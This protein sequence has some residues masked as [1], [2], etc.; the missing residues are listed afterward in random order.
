MSSLLLKVLTMKNHSLWLLICFSLLYL[1]SCEKEPQVVSVSGISLATRSI[2]LVEGE[3][4]D[5]VA[6]II[7]SDANNQRVTW[8]SSNT[9]I[10]SVNNGKVTAIKIGH[11]II[12]ATTEDGG[13]TASC[14]VSVYTPT[15]I[16]KDIVCYVNC[17]EQDFVVDIRSNIPFTCSID[18]NDKSWLSLV[19]TKALDTK[20]VSFHTSSNTSYV[21][22][23]AVIRVVSGSL[24]RNVV[25][26]QAGQP[27][28]F[29][30]Q[31]LADYMVYNYDK[32]HDK[33]ITSDEVDLI[34]SFSINSKTI[35]SIDGLQYLS[36]LKDLTLN[37]SVG[38]GILELDMS[39]FKSLE[40]LLCDNTNISHLLVSGA[41]K[42]RTLSCSDNNLTE[43]DLRDCSDLVTLR[44]SR[45]KLKSLD[46]TSNLQIQELMC[47]YCEIESL[48]LPKSSSCLQWFWCSNNNITSLDLSDFHDLVYI[49]CS[50]NE[51][52]DLGELIMPYLEQ[53]S[54]FNNRISSLNLSS[55]SDLQYLGCWNNPISSLDCSNLVQLQELY[56]DNCRIEELNVSSCY[57]IRKLSCSK[58]TDEAIELKT[59]YIPKSQQCSL[60]IPKSTN[61]IEID[62]WEEEDD[63]IITLFDPYFKDY[64]VTANI[65]AGE[66]RSSKIDRN[67]DG[68]ISV[69]EA[70]LVRSIYIKSSTYL[71]SLSG[72]EYL[73]NLEH[74]SIGNDDWF[75][76]RDKRGM[77]SEADLSDNTKLRTVWILGQNL[78]S[79]SLPK[80]SSLLEDVFIW[81]C[82]LKTI[83]LS[84]FMDLKRLE[85]NDTDIVSLD[86]SHNSKLSYIQVNDNKISEL[87]LGSHPSLEWLTIANNPIKAIDVS[88]FP[89]LYCLQCSNTSIVSLDVH[90]N[91][92]LTMLSCESDSLE[93]L[94]L[95]KNYYL[96]M[97]SFMCGSQTNIIIR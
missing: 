22:R 46:L 34:T 6:T 3:I 14:E 7:P 9:A 17:D 4:F 20:T 64:L 13:F 97:T 43:L 36:N 50:N 21:T 57:S 45:N 65:D 49:D 73:N 40:S 32:N 41:S 90:K 86:L 89:D 47:D 31:A 61:V 12:T 1:I 24:E 54:C 16:P 77:L 95:F 76:N 10:A 58:T 93:T 67:G 79:L 5:L 39:G 92:S 75:H 60:I 53:L 59:L 25:V 69:G 19:Q 84:S 8:S 26:S 18:D 88:V 48:M 63:S 28:P 42:L 35:H 30:D 33:H 71:K 78:E 37:M 72:I 56:C 68:E 81:G 83:D 55:L 11:S 66:S 2:E 85:L 27:I 15:V 62:A 23:Q 87:I 82:P 94:Y 44:C 51:I 52:D 38:G 80:S 96:T 29:A 91:T 74:L 70:R